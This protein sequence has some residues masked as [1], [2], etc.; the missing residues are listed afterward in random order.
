MMKISSVMCAQSMNMKMMTKLLFVIY[1][2]QQFTKLVMVVSFLEEFLKEI[3]TAKD[4]EY[5]NRI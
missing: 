1:V 3:G 4:V 5:F 2:M